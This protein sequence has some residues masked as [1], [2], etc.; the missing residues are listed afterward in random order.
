MNA[1]RVGG[2]NHEMTSLRVNECPHIVK[3]VTRGWCCAEES[4]R[5]RVDCMKEG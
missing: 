2:S 5:N 4:A 1:A 3:N